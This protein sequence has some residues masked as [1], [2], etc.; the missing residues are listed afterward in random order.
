MKKNVWV[1]SF[2]LFFLLLPITVRGEMAQQIGGV[3]CVVEQV[4]FP[5]LSALFDGNVR[6]GVKAHQSGRLTFESP[7]G[8]GS[9][10]LIFDTEYGEFTLVNNDSGEAVTVGEDRFLH[11][12]L[13]VEQLFGSAPASVT[14]LFEHT[15][16]PL[17]ELSVYTPGQVPDTVQRWEP[18]VEDGADLVLFSTHADDEQLFFAGLLPYYAG[19][20]GYRVQVV[21]LT[22]HRNLSDF[23]TL[24]CHEALDGLWNVGVRSY[25]VF[26]PFGDY[27]AKNRN[28]GYSVLKVMG[29]PEEDLLSYVVE[30]IRRFRPQVAVGHDLN[31]EYGHGAHMVYA[32]LLT[33]AV[34]ITGDPTAFPESAQRWG[35]WEIPKLYL[36]LYEENPIVMDWDRPLAAFSGMTAFQVTKELGFPSHVSQQQAFSWYMSG[37]EMASEVQDYSPCQ[38]GLYWTTV[39]TD[40]EKNDF[41]ENLPRDVPQEAQTNQAVEADAETT[42]PQALPEPTVPPGESPAP[43][44]ASSHSGSRIAI[45]GAAILL[46]LLVLYLCLKKFHSTSKAA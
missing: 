16:V 38:Y 33:R 21:Y 22:N 36:H 27:Y 46:V 9:V 25:P 43:I 45:A 5:N 40:T 35:T 14:L 17:Q 2:L 32:D 18:P 29:T 39:G 8:I 10:Y 37:A 19:E 7:Q 4:G 44:P 26:G 12:F 11:T 24:R 23:P 30:Q 42:L 31:G 3:D 34:E 1:F 28:D 6:T 41:F 20:L 13:N 15:P